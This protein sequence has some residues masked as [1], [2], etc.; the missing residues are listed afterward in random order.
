VGPIALSSERKPIRCLSRCVIGDGERIRSAEARPDLLAPI[1]ASLSVFSAHVAKKE[2][3]KNTE[4]LKSQGTG[5]RFASCLSPRPLR[6]SERRTP[7]SR[8][9]S[10]GGISRQSPSLAPLALSPHLPQLLLLLLDAGTT[11][12]AIFKTR[13]M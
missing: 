5:S 12:T 1:K 11:T 6:L 13:E 7:V 4:L 10:D 2:E 3:N 9:T 8:Y